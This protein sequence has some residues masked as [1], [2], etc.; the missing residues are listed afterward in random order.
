MASSVLYS[1]ADHESLRVG[2]EIRYLPKLRTP[3]LI[4]TTVYTAARRSLGHKGKRIDLPAGADM[5]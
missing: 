5:L 2:A 1:N 4:K 3:A